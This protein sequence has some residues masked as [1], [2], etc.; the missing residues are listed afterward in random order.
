MTKNSTI[1]SAILAFALVLR[2]WGIGFGLPG[3]YHPDEERI[4]HH[5]LA[6]GLGDLNPHYFNYPS[7]PMYLLFF[8][9]GAFY[10]F[11]R[12][13]GVF[14]GVADLQALF[15]TDPTAFYLI[16]RATGAILGTLTVLLAYLLGKKAYGRPA[17]HA[18]GSILAVTFLHAENAHYIATDIWL[19]FFIAAAFLPILEILRGG[20]RKAYIWAGFLAGLGAASKY[21][22]ATLALPIFLAHW[23]NPRAPG[24]RWRRIRDGRLWL[25]ASCM[26]LAFFI[27]SPY[28]FL[29]FPKFWE[30]FRFISEHM[31]RGVYDTGGGRH[32]LDYL[33]LFFRDPMN[34]A[35]ARWNTL[36]LFYLGGT[37][38]GLITGRKK[39]WLLLVYPALYF[40]MIGSWGKCNPRYLIPVFPALAVLSGGALVAL[41]RRA[42]SRPLFR[43]A[44]PLGCLLLAISPVLNISL[45][46]SMLSRTDTREEARRWIEE[47]ISPGEKIAL[48]W[49][50][51][52]TVQLQETAAGIQD[53]IR[54]YQEGRAATIHHPAEQMA[55]VHQMRLAAGR[56][57]AY[58]IVRIGAVEGLSLLPEGYDLA[59]L[60]GRG[61]QY[62][63]ISSEVY[64][65][66][67]GEKGRRKY[68]VHAA[69]YDTLFSEYTPIQVFAP[70]NQP[71]P[72]IFIYK[73]TP[74][75]PSI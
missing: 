32:W 68:P 37:A 14:A 9:Y 46:D 33:F 22:A 16:G 51:N 55:A 65:W 63:V 18:A 11:G 27:G 41:W 21:N 15:F 42:S 60:R 57:K 50:N 49:D 36:G 39:E 58:N 56:G 71:G 6:F 53:K 31:K 67:Q 4:V 3:V 48:E 73:L 38:W 23:W 64:S 44:C 47:N 43:I 75:E 54:A 59:E 70:E 61:A 30:D 19:T 45:N 74:F 13:V 34:S 35:P 20:E 10:A 69:F 62:L 1:L 66:F 8:E 72:T 29:D 17:G 28:C 2:L 25:A 24:N 26:L 7:L 5:A 52:A 12:L 40:L